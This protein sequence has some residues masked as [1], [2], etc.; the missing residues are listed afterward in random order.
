MFC[1]HVLDI[2]NPQL[3]FLALKDP[4]LI[5]LSFHNQPPKLCKLLKIPISVLKVVTHTLQAIQN[6]HSSSIV[7]CPRSAR[8]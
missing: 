4:M 8:S 2:Q 1:I 6:S 3:P 7:S 5:S